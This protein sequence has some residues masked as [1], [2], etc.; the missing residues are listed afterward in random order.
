MDLPSSCL[1]PSQ[2]TVFRLLPQQTGVGLGGPQ[3]SILWAEG[4]PWVSGGEGLGG[5]GRGGAASVL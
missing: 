4:I 3:S 1:P 2:H 5:K